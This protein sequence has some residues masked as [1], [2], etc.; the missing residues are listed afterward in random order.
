[1]DETAFTIWLDNGA[2]TCWTF[3]A[4]RFTNGS[5]EWEH[6]VC[7]DAVG[8]SR[9]LLN[10]ATVLAS[11]ASFSSRAIHALRVVSARAFARL[12]RHTQAT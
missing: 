9:V 1:M 8:S 4:E 3:D 5:L 6:K 11:N 7:L 10:A 12:A 2:S